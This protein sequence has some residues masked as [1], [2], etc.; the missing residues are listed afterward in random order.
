VDYRYDALVENLAYPELL[1]WI[2]SDHDGLCDPA[3]DALSLSLYY[4]WIQEVAIE[5]W[6]PGIVDFATDA[7]E[8]TQAQQDACEAF[9]TLASD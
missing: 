8:V 3:A 9:H 2:D 6:T 5:L 7:G 1:V 4:G